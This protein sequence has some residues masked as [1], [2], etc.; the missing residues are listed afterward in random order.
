M[1]IG[2]DL[3][4]RGDQWCGIVSDAT[5]QIVRGC[6]VRSPERF[7]ALAGNR[8]EWAGITRHAAFQRLHW[9]ALEGAELA[10]L[11]A[12]SAMIGD[13]HGLATRLDL[14]EHLEHLGLEFGRGQGIG[15]GAAPSFNGKRHHNGN[16]GHRN[17]SFLL[18]IADTAQYVGASIL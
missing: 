5:H 2:K 10:D 17:G 18:R 3:A 6:R 4:V 8:L 12:G 7:P 9:I 14:A 16:D 1:R 15:H 11:D 13:D